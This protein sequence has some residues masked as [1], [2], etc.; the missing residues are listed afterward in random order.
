MSVPLCV[1]PAMC[2]CVICASCAGDWLSHRCAVLRRGRIHTI[3]QQSCLDLL[4]YQGGCPACFGLLGAVANRHKCTCI[5]RVHAC[6]AVLWWCSGAGPCVQFVD[7]SPHTHV[8]VKACWVCCPSG[9]LVR[10]MMVGS[11]GGGI[12]FAR[13]Y[14]MSCVQHLRVALFPTFCACR[15]DRLPPERSGLCAGVLLKQRGYNSAGLCC[16]GACVSCVGVLWCGV[17]NYSKAALDLMTP[18]LPKASGVCVYFPGRS[19]AL[20]AAG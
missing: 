4:L 16:L 3:V 19:A 20:T 14:V 1:F 18:E 15:G 10:H 8:Y 17:Y 12:G 13:L 9:L 5:Q 7:R 11:A 2:W 6:Q